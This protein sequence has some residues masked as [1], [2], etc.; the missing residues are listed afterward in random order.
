PGGG[1][2]TLFVTARLTSDG[3]TRGSSARVTVRQGSS[4]GDIVT[5]AEVAIRGGRLGRTIVPFD[6]DRDQYRLD[7]FDWVEGFRLEVVRGNDLLDGSIE[8]PGQTLITSPVGNSTFRR[9][10][11]QPLLIQWRDERGSPAAKTALRLDRAKIDRDVA[12]GIAV[13]RIEVADLVVGDEKV[14]VSRSNEVSLSG[15]ASGSSLSASTEHEIEF[16]VE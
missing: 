4:N 13:E 11:N 16:K 14:R 12:P 9:A 15:G 6:A 5:N 2:G 1:T 8:A 3:S 10:D 7:S